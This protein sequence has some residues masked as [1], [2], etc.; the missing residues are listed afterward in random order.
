MDAPTTAS[1]YQC[2]HQQVVG[3]GQPNY[4]WFK[5][6]SELPHFN[7]TPLYH[8]MLPEEKLVN[9]IEKSWRAC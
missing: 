6:A 9:D 3:A 5:R 1:E 7:R 2:P 8:S 4:E